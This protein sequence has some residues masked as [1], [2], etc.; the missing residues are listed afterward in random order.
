MSQK[1][2]YQTRQPKIKEA[3]CV[4]PLDLEMG[5]QRFQRYHSC[6]S[7]FCKYYP[8]KELECPIMKKLIK[9]VNDKIKID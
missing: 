1:C 8:D 2:P 9:Y 4:I 3:R 7:W 5:C 6:G